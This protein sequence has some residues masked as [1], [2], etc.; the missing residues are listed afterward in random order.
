MFRSG[1]VL[2]LA[3]LLG[4][5]VTTAA[6]PRAC[7]QNAAHTPSDVVRDFYKAMREHRF[8]EAFALTI[9]KS[10]V[11]GL[12]AEEMED[13]RP[14]FEEKAALIPPSIEIVGEQINGNTA[15]VFVRIPAT[16]NTPQVTS[17]PVNLFNS[18]GWIIGTE[19]DLAEVK[20][21]GHR[22]F[23]DALIIEHEGDVN[24]LLKRMVV[25]EGIYSQQHAGAYGELPALIAAGM[26]SADAVDP[27][28]SGYNFRITLT[29]DGKGFVANAE[30]ARHGRTGKLSF[31]MDQTG[32]IKSSNTGGK[33]LKP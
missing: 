13:L 17:E 3:I 27:K 12:S 8:N 32:V 19:M 15:I 33:P 18:G 7:A 30:P 20:K 16:D 28:L 11:E 4:A 26:L 5:L 21:A 29:K 24:D 10:A 23:L 22:Y 1:F 25:L 14:G 6:P 31:W 9:Y 2:T